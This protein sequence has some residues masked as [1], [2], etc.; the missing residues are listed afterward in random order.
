M[1]DSIAAHWQSP[2]GSNETALVGTRTIDEAVRMQREWAALNRWLENDMPPIDEVGAPG[3]FTPALI[4][5]G[6]L[7]GRDSS[8]GLQIAATRSAAAHGLKPLDGLSDGFT[9]L[10]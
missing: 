8:S 2:E 3:R 9:K 4:D 5:A 6:L 10:G 1:R 7:N